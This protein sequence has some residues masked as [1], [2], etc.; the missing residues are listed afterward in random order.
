MA[1]FKNCIVIMV[2]F[3]LTLNFIR[4]FI[5]NLSEKNSVVHNFVEAQGRSKTYMGRGAASNVSK[6]SSCPNAPSRQEA[7]QI[8]F[9]G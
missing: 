5:S 6:M 3:Q 8:I 4:R 2:W 7:I 9:I 1:Y